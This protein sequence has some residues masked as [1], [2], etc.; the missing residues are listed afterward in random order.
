MCIR[1][2]NR[3]AL[4][5]AL[6]ASFAITGCHSSQQLLDPV[7]ALQP[8]KKQKQQP[9]FIEEISFA[10]NS[11]TIRVTSTAPAVIRTEKKEEKKEF[12]QTLSNLM[13]VKYAQVLGIVPNAVTNLSL[14]NFIDEW[15]GVRYRLGGNDKTGIDCSAFVQKLY[16]N[17]FC[18]NM[19]RTAIEQF[20]TCEKSKSRDSLKEGDLVFFKT[21]GK[22][23][24]VT[25]VGIYLK[26]DF[27]V[28]ASSSQG[29]TI[30]SLNENYWSRFFVGVGKMFGKE[31]SF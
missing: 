17:V 1:K 19:L 16:E 30:S 18:T 21:K 24:P 12:Y 3:I 29:V 13:Q 10:G 7:T 26:N 31:S 8:R 4:S 9:A 27:F 6:I 15:Y 20:K 23:K 22:K 2:L 11:K 5:F 28:H 14:Y 25:H